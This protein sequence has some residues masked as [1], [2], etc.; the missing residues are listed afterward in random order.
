M[1]LRAALFRALSDAKKNSILGKDVVLRKTMLDECKGEKFEA[2][3]SAFAMAVLRKQKI[4]KHD[5]HAC[6]VPG[7]Q[8]LLRVQDDQLLPLVLAHH[9]ALRRSLHTR[10]TLRQQARAYSEQLGHYREELLQ[11]DRTAKEQ[12]GNMS[13]TTRQ[14]EDVVHQVMNTWAGD[15]KWATFLL[16]GNMASNK[17]TELPRPFDEDS[18]ISDPHVPHPRPTSAKSSSLVEQLEQRIRHHEDRLLRWRQYQATLTHA[19]KGQPRPEGPKGNV[20]RVSLIPPFTKHLHLHTNMD[21]DDGT[22]TRRAMS[23]AY[24]RLLQGLQL[25]LSSKTTRTRNQS[26]STEPVAILPAEPKNNSPIDLPSLNIV[27]IPSSTARTPSSGPPN[28]P[29]RSSQTIQSPENNGGDSL[30]CSWQG[31][32]D[33]TL[34][35]LP[36]LEDTDSS[37]TLMLKVEHPQDPPMVNI[38]AAST[39]LTAR[40]R[41]SLLAA[42]KLQSDALFSTPTKPT[43]HDIQGIAGREPEAIPPRVATLLERTRESMSLLSHPTTTA[44]P[45]KTSSQDQQA[46]QA[47]PVNQFETPRP[48]RLGPRISIVSLDP[49]TPRSADSTP[50]EKLFD[51]TADYASVF[52]SRPRIAISPIL[53]P[54]HHSFE[55]DSVLGNGKHNQV[56]PDDEQDS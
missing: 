49:H 27:H 12:T 11:R 51:E 25:E 26:Q 24:Q 4:P 2:L 40:T 52:K 33:K 9:S 50:R 31:S 13:I 16:E 30:D 23:W 18:P 6:A 39:S 36:D 37:P 17:S 8:H 19:G 54:E 10:Q 5:S 53:S 15:R 42:S 45:K 21:A 46:Q 41:D 3:L 34:V 55:T 20:E 48:Q 14:H 29:P 7:C 28:S 32:A 35:I 22:E 43:A 44:L 47:S 38:S 56:A 1:N